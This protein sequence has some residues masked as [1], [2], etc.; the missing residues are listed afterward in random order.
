M[1]NSGILACHGHAGLLLSTAAC[2]VIPGA[3]F[4]LNRCSRGLW[5]T[6]PTLSAFLQGHGVLGLG[7]SGLRVWGFGGLGGSVWKHNLRPHM[8]S[9][10]W[11][12]HSSVMHGWMPAYSL[13]GLCPM[14]RD[15]ASEKPK[16]LRV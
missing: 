10:L 14:I 1:I 12:K 2:K 8:T 4:A 15:S 9:E 3:D 7:N 16:Q 6:I 5:L 11:K 13:P